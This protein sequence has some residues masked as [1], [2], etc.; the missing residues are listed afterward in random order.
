MK[1]LVFDTETTWFINKKETDLTLQP[2]I[3]QFAWIVWELKDGVFTETQRINQFIKPKI[4]IP[5]DSSQVHHIYDI[6]VKN[7]PNIEEKIEDFIQV[8]NSCDAIIWHNIEYDEDMLKLELKRLQKEY[9]YQPK[10]IIC[11]MK[12]T[13]DF[14]A[15]RWNGERFK[16]PKLWE[17]YKELFWEYFL[18]AHDA[19]VDVEATLKAF[20]ELHKRNILGIKE[21][22]E[23]I[24][25][26]F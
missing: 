7:A 11:T 20:L 21:K 12:T 9:L 6:D 3:I 2:Y 1:I 26:L 14:C 13:V 4:A 22:K 24:L 10:Q 15:I 23:E 16:Y 19:I 8:I 17:L 18:W 25:S 5:Y